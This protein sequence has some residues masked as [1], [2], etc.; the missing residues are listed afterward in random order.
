MKNSFIVIILLFIFSVQAIYAQIDDLRGSSEKCRIK[1]VFNKTDTKVFEEDHKLSAF[2]FMEDKKDVIKEANP[3]TLI[4]QFYF[5]KTNKF[6][7]TVDEFKSLLKDSLAQPTD[8]NIIYMFQ[9]IKGSIFI[10]KG[11]DKLSIIHLNALFYSKD[12]SLLDEIFGKGKSSRIDTT[13]SR[14]KNFTHEFVPFSEASDNES[15][16]LFLYRGKSVGKGFAC[17]PNEDVDILGTLKSLY[18]EKF[19][20]DCEKKEAAR[21]DDLLMKL[22]KQKQD[23]SVRYINLLNNI[24]R[25]PTNWTFFTGLNFNS[26]SVTPKSSFIDDNIKFRTNG[27]SNSIGVLYYLK[28]S[29]DT[30]SNNFYLSGSLSIGTSTYSMFK[31]IDFDYIKLN[32][33]YN[34]IS[35]LHAYDEGINSSFVNIP[36]GVGY[37]WKDKGKLPVFFQVT[38]NGLLGFNKL[39][40]NSAQGTIDYR[41]YYSSSKI[42]VSDQPQIG[43]YEKDSLNG[44]PT[45]KENTSFTYGAVIDTKVLYNFQSLPL[46]GYINVGYIFANTV[47][48][49]NG[50]DFISGSKYD[51][52]SI[53]NSFDNFGSSPFYVGF[54]ISYEL[55]K[56]IRNK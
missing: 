16:Y 15:G 3:R 18:N 29:H 28:K 1:S 4:V 36:F 17:D 24:N 11:P 46:S 35:S 7:K 20:K 13:S 42:W 38:F 6:H 52:N 8:I 49:S 39:S 45:Y 43:L 56:I 12:K 47:T 26:G 31:K 34:S 27:F 9:Q 44:N 23:D 40:V 5:D 55:R 14:L 10:D 32:K 25:S 19:F 37:E 21:K 54:G 30:L 2:T 51:F 53:L 50:S 22:Q 41:R 33:D 48:H